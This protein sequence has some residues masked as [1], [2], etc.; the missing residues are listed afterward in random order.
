MKIWVQQKLH[1]LN[2]LH[3][4]EYILYISIE[5]MPYYIITLSSFLVLWRII[6]CD[7]TSRDKKKTWDL[8]KLITR[9]NVTSVTSHY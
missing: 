6:M 4:N 8:E 9:C 5:V 7:N 1:F 2:V 3:Y